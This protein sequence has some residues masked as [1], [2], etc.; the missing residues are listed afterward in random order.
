M[1]SPIVNLVYVRKYRSRRV[2]HPCVNFT[3]D[4]NIK[5]MKHKLTVG[6][7]CTCEIQGY[8]YL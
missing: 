4:K 7:A 2:F 6:G 5:I 3:V 8:M 1:K